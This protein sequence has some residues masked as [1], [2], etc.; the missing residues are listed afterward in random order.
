MADRPDSADRDLGE[1][2][3]SARIRDKVAGFGVTFT[4]MF[5]RV[6]T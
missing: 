5:T 2:Q 6:V 3:R 4:T 1:E